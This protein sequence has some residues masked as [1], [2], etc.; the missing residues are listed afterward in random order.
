MLHTP[1]G[2]DNDDDVKCQGKIISYVVQWRKSAKKISV[3]CVISQARQPEKRYKLIINRRRLMFFSLCRQINYQTEHF[4]I[5]V[6]DF[7]NSSSIIVR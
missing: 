5:P 6:N 1:V 4:Q 2:D 7:I 3:S